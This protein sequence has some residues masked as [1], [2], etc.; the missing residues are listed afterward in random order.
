MTTTSVNE[1][2]KMQA[3]A[4]RTVRDYEKE[5][6]ERI[7]RMSLATAG[8]ELK[9]SRKFAASMADQA[10]KVALDETTGA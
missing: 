10:E 1:R 5:A 4:L 6:I 9:G 3:E 7:R 2:S 8:L